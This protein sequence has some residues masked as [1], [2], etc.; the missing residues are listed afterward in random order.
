MADVIIHHLRQK[1]EKLALMETVDLLKLGLMTVLVIIPV[2]VTK[3]TACHSWQA[4]T[5]TNL[6][7]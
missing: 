4:V 6:S 5:V 2:I 3:Y 1:I 7:I